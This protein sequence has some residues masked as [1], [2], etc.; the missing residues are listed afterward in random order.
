MQG[1]I[2]H[3]LNCGSSSDVSTEKERLSLV[4]IFR[5]FEVDSLVKLKSEYCD[6]LRVTQYIVPLS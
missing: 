4:S 1:V 2:F 3:G 5:L 6:R